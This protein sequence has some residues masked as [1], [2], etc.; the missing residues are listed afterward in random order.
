MK[1]VAFVVV[2]VVV[3]GLGLL[4]GSHMARAQSDDL[5]VPK[6]PYLAP[7][8]KYGHWKVTFKYGKISSPETTGASA[9]TSSA[10]P[11]PASPAPQPETLEA[12]NPTLPAAIDT[13]K[14]GD[15]SGVTL[16]FGNG[17]TKEYTCQGDWVLN[18]SPEGAQLSIASSM[19]LP[20]PY[21]TIGF[22]LLDGVKIDPSTF[23][24][25]AKHDGV[26]AFHYKSGDVD[27]WIDPAS[28]LPLAAKQDAVE[29]SYQFLPRPTEP[30]SI[31]ADQAALLKKE[32]QA[33]AATR[34]MR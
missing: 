24:E 18:S 15:L 13:I 9:S 23:R 32:R 34:A 30:F 31:P 6:P 11:P 1:P 22:I 16:T 29:V 19:S 33:D 8:P 26:I 28:M 25:T 4:V 14:T 2:V 20:Y 17:I 5:P 7:V 3:V 10:T 27:V 12:P 21:Y